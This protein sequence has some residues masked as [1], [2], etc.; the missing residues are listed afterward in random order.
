MKKNILNFTFGLIGSI[1]G[2]LI[3]IVGIYVS[4][5]NWI[6]IST[7]IVGAFL[8]FS[9]NAS[10]VDFKNKKIKYASL[11]FG[12]IKIGYQISLKEDMYIKII[13]SGKENKTENGETIFQHY[14]LS[15]FDS[16]N[17]EILIL[18]KS[19]K[20]DKIESFSKQFSQ[21]FNVLIK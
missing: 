5:Y 6:G 15:L 13:G 17:K 14:K 3:L 11:L 16:N 21:E 4:F 9:H 7:I 20:I 1:L 2:F 10:F 18:L 12:I 8:A 19:K